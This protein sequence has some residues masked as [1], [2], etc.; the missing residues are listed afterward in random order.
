MPGSA[1]QG[2]GSREDLARERR[3]HPRRGSARPGPSDRPRAVPAHSRARVRLLRR[4]RPGTLRRGT[5]SLV[6]RPRRRRR[7]DALARDLARSSDRRTA[8]PPAA[9]R[10]VVGR[11]RRRPGSRRADDHRPCRSGVVCVADRSRGRSG[12]GRHRDRRGVA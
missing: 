8:S 7:H 2:P 5:C 9:T 1:T 3:R 10:R 4:R 12:V 6:A 11:I